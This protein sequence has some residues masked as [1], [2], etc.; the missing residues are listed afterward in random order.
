M[1][2]EHNRC[3]INDQFYYYNFW[4]GELHADGV[5]VPSTELPA[6]VYVGGWSDRSLGACLEKALGIGP[7]E[8]G[9]G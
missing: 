3:S 6:E 2:L 4:A 5:W 7:L 8:E 9:K 1:F